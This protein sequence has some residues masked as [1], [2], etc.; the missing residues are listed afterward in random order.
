VKRTREQI[1]ADL[2]REYEEEL[3]QLLAWEKSTKKPTLSQIEEQVLIARKKMSEAM[4]KQM[5]AGQEVGSPAEVEKCPKCGKPMEDKGKE[6]KLVETRAG[7]I[8]MERTRYYCPDC[9]IGVFP[10]G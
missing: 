9:K 1:K 8:L 10:P 4:L 3:D 5:L 2:L 7:S 6:P